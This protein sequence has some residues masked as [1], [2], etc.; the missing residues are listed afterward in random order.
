M[1]LFNPLSYVVELEAT[2][3]SKLT[4]D[5]VARFEVTLHRELSVQTWKILSTLIGTLTAL[6]AVTY[7]LVKNVG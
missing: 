3:G 7:Y 5:D 2:G 4:R 1:T 6:V